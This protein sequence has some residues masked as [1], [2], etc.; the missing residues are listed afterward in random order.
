MYIP[1]FLFENSRRI[2]YGDTGASFIPRHDG[3]GLIVKADKI[4]SFHVDGG[5]KPGPN[6][7][8]HK[9]GRVEMIF[10]GFV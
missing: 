9:H 3:C 7:T 6:A 4:V 5:L 10:E 8:C 2:T 1:D